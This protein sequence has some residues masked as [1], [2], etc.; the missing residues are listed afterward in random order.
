VQTPEREG[1]PAGAD[2]IGAGTLAADGHTVG[3][4]RLGRRCEGRPA[5]QNSPSPGHRSK[6]HG[7][8]A[9][10]P[11][12]LLPM[13]DEAAVALAR[14]LHQRGEEVLG[15]NGALPAV[16]LCAAELTRRRLC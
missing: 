7:G 13:P 15:L 16:E 10:Y 14:T 5:G 1:P 6:L 11:P 8:D 9:P 4:L 2:S 12:F 3:D